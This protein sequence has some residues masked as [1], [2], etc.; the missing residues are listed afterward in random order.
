MDTQVPES[1]PE[2]LE[3]LARYVALQEQER[4]L[5]EEKAELQGRLR[6]H[7]APSGCS[8]WIV[9]AGGQKL[10]VACHTKTEI[11]YDEDLL[12]SR[13]GERYKAILSPSLKKIR[14]ALPRLGAYL[15]PVLAQ[16]GSPD[17]E[18]VRAAVERGDV[19][20]SEFDGAFVKT[21]KQTVAV[22]RVRLEPDAGPV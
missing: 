11:E 1:T 8:K 12:A 15:E 21:E 10:K 16:V 13:L 14:A 20:T 17:P 5:K 22:M 3:T 2:I 18:K 19:S 6:T 7:M 4:H 9:E